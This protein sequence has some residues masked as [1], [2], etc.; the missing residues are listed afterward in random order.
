LPSVGDLKKI[1]TTQAAL[2]G[3]IIR[4]ERLHGEE[5]LR[6]F[7]RRGHMIKNL[8]ESLGFKRWDIVVLERFFSWAGHIVRLQRRDDCR[9]IVRILNWRNTLELETCRILGGRDG[10]QGHQGRVFIRRWESIFF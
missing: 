7:A 1:R 10:R 2:Y 6:F 9:L 8:R 4:I 3:K 5:D